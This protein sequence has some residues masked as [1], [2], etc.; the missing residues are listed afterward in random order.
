MCGFLG[1]FE[2]DLS[3]AQAMMPLSHRGPDSEDEYQNRNL[4]LRHFR[5]AIIGSETTARQPM[6][7]FNGRVVMAYNGEIYNYKELAKQIGQPEL[8]EHGDTRVLVEFLAYYGLDKIDLLNGMFTIA[9]YFEDSRDLYLVRDR[10]GIKPLYYLKH[11]GIY[12][13]SEIKSLRP[14]KNV[15]VSRDRLIDYLETASYPS[16]VDTMYEDI[17]QV[18]A[19][20]WVKYGN[21]ALE[22]CRWYDFRAQIRAMQDERLSVD[23]YEDL[24]EDSIKLRLRSDVPISLH[25]SAGTDST[26]LLLKVKESWGWDFPLTTFTMAFDDIDADESALAQSYCDQID[27]QNYR[28]HLNSKEVPELA[29]DLHGYTDEPYGGLPTIAYYKMNKVEREQ[30]FIVSIEGQGGDEAFGGY[31]YHV[32]M[33][34]LDLHESGRDP[35][36]LELMLKMHGL[37]SSVAIQAAK[38]LIEAGFQSH[39]DM[40]DLRDSNAR[41]AEKFI[42]WLRTIQLYDILQNKIPRTLRFNDRASMANGREVRFPLLDHR[43][44]EYAVAFGHR[45]KFQHGHTKAP[46]REIIRRHLPCD[47]SAPK[48]SVVTPQTRWFQGEL[49]PWVLERTEVL[50]KSG[51][52]P[53]VYFNK[54]DEFYA[55]PAPTNSFALWQLVNLSY[56][57][58]FL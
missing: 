11:K 4:F 58:E 54:V 12:F 26:A 2:A 6:T 28:V 32:Y 30:G 8:A 5:L 40:T 21:G 3:L 36:L 17:V 22:T 33:A 51:S 38:K 46:L 35:K 1:C 9:A 37:E 25:Y 47:Y 53:A 42:D 10:F 39:T 20:T 45:E 14:V 44:L 57:T 50:R 52:I 24:V 27:V 23:H 43:V 49:K 48:R 19:G 13:A 31:L 15:S 41:P 55:D 7:S 56:F 18:D 29:E 34:I 16:G